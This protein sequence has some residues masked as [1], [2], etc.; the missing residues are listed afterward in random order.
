M[1]KNPLKLC[2]EFVCW[3]E[4][5]SSLLPLY[6]SFPHCSVHFED[7]AGG[8]WGTRQGIIREDLL[9]PKP[10]LDDLNLSSLHFWKASIII[11]KFL[12]DGG[13]FSID[14][15]RAPSSGRSVIGCV[16]SLFFQL[17]MARR[18]TW[19]GWF[20]WCCWP[21]F[22]LR[23]RYGIP[24]WNLKMGALVDKGSRGSFC[25]D[26]FFHASR[27]LKLAFMIGHS[28]VQYHK[29]RHSLRVLYCWWKKSWIR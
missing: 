18:E 20:W 12:E 10:Q 26:A 14:C 15:R 21:G 11:P 16:L 25:M 28:E 8:L 24:T 23:W 2:D 4:S 27:C 3:S 13:L 17:L 7:V 1:G 22:G 29:N 6:A 19:V 5:S 9:F